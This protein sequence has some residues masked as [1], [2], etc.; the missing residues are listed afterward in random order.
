[1]TISPRNLTMLGSLSRSIN[2]EYPLRP[3]MHVRLTLPDDMTLD[4][5]ERVIRYI[6]SL[7]LP[8]D[9]NDD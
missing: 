3:G 2:H 7:V 8:E 1:M 5:A 9:N 4:E 6:K